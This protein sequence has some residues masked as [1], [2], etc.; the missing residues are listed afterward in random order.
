MKVGQIEVFDILRDGEIFRSFDVLSKALVYLAAARELQ[1]D[2]DF[3]LRIVR[4]KV[5]ER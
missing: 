1:P 2:H 5:A 3:E 4:P